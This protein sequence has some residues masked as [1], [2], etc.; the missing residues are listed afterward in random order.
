MSPEAKLL[1][2]DPLEPSDKPKLELPAS[3]DPPING[4]PNHQLVWIVSWPDP[5][6]LLHQVSVLT[7]AGL[8]DDLVDRYLEAPGIWAVHW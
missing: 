8:A 3:C 4:V 6:L 7:K 5:Q 2:S 1:S